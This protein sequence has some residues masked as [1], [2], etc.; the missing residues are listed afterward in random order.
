MPP[1]LGTGPVS[2]TLGGEVTKVKT[3]GE[4]VTSIINPSHK[5]AERY[6]E[7]EV[8]IE[9]ESLMPVINDVLTVQQ[10][11]DLVSFLQAQYEVTPPEHYPYALYAY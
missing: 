5:L 7:E 2:V 8:S 6:P 11:I 10:L 1:F 9:G 3:Y 4:L